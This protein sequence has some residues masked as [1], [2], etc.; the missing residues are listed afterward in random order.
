MEKAQQLMTLSET[1]KLLRISKTKLYWERKAGRLKTLKFGRA[2]R[3]R[4]DDLHQYCEAAAGVKI[5]RGRE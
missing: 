2:V 4:L 1:A 3:V 5:H